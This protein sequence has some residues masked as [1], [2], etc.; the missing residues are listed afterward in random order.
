MSSAFITFLVVFFIRNNHKINAKICQFFAMFRMPLCIYHALSLF[1]F[2][3]SVTSVLAKVEGVFS[4]AA[5][6]GYLVILIIGYLD[7]WFIYLSVVV[8]IALSDVAY[9]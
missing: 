2:W 1:Y 9:C 3:S 4:S 5:F 8:L 6:L 7:A